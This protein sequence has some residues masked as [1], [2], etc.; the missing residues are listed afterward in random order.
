MSVSFIFLFYLS[1]MSDPFIFL[2]RTSIPWIVSVS[3]IPG[4]VFVSFIPGIVFVSFI[5]GSVI[6]SPPRAQYS[7]VA[8]GKV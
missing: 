2:L 4:M 7:V 6:I 5:P 3:F 8:S 1:I